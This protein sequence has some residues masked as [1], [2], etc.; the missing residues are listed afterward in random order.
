MEEAAE[1]V[2]TKDTIMED[3]GGGQCSSVKSARTVSSV[4]T[5]KTESMPQAQE[6]SSSLHSDYVSHLLICIFSV[7]FVVSNVVFY[8]AV[9]AF[10]CRSIYSFTSFLIVFP[11]TLHTSFNFMFI[12]LVIF[13]LLH[14]FPFVLVRDF[15]IIIWLIFVLNIIVVLL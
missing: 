7:V 12:L 14:L 2:L 1:L 5:H 4:L 13:C 11:Y 15:M 10:V 6:S 9:F 3:A 8:G